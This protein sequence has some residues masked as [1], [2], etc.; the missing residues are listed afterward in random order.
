VKS[1]NRLDRIGRFVRVAAEKVAELNQLGDQF[2][3]HL[4]VVRWAA[5]SAGKSFS[6]LSIGGPGIPMRLQ[7]PL[8]LLKASI[9]ELL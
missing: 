5:K 6:A 1:V 3:G 9:S 4:P 7:N 2:S 8:P